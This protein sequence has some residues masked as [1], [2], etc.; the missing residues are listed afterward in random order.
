MCALPERVLQSLDFTVNRAI[1]KLQL[2]ALT[3]QLSNS[4]GIF[5]LLPYRVTICTAPET[6]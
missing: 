1:M 5:V 4:A 2:K 3:Q 6:F